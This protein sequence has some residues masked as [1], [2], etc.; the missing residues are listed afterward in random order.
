MLATTWLEERRADYALSQKFIKT[1][2]DAGV[3]IAVGSDSGV[4]NVAFGWGT[5]QEMRQLVEA[6]LTPVAAIA[7]ATGNAARVLEGND[8]EFGVVAAGKI[9]DLVVLGAD[10]TSDIR[11]T[12][13]IERVMQVGRWLDR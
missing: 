7:A 3:M 2:H 9:A 11:N 4:G 1:M 13:R 6:G 8:A 5:H 12:R 10:P